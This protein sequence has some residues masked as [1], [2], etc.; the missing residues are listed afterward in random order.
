M[1]V[2]IQPNERHIQITELGLDITIKP[3]Y[4]I[5]KLLDESGR[6]YLK[7]IL[8]EKLD[9]TVSKTYTGLLHIS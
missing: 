3:N 2:T 8:L 6:T 7:N 4:L 1:E 9:D 5:H